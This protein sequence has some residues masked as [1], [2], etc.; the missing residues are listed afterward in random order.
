MAALTPPSVA[1][2]ACASGSSTGNSDWGRRRTAATASR[3]RADS[4]ASG[5]WPTATRCHTSSKLRGAGEGRGVVPA[6]VEVAGVAVDVADRGVGDG[7]AVEAGGHIDQGGHG[8][9][10]GWSSRRSTLI[11]STLIDVRYRVGRDAVRRRGRGCPP[12]RRAEGDAVRLRQP[13]ADPAS[14]RRRRPHVA[15]LRRRPRCPAP[16]RSASGRRAATLDRR[17]DRHRDHR[18]R[19]DR[20]PVPRSRCRRA[21]PP[22]LV[23]TGRRAAVDRDAPRGRRLATARARRSRRS[24]GG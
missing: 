13:G 20:R 7:N 22:L 16:T 6:V 19:R 18:A 15:V 1:P 3:K 17:P 24:P 5:R 12:A 4:A 10:L 11:R 8:S 23:R 2:R 21:R 14:R 9:I